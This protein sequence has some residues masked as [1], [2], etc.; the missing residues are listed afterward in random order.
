MDAGTLKKIFQIGETI[1]VE[2]KRCGNS[3]E[4]DVYETAMSFS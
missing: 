2:F 4:N 1:A 3:I